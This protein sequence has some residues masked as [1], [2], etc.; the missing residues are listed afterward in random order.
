MLL[1]FFMALGTWTDNQQLGV[2]WETGTLALQF[3]C[4]KFRSYLLIASSSPAF[5]W[6]NQLLFTWGKFH[7]RLQRGSIPVSSRFATLWFACN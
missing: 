1:N 5:L 7:F 4:G 2:R 3:A 6:L